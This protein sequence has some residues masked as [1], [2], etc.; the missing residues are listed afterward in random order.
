M[1]DSWYFLERR[2]YW[3]LL[4][5]AGDCWWRRVAAGL[6]L[7]LAGTGPGAPGPKNQTASRSGGLDARGRWARAST[8]EWLRDGSGR[9]GR[10]R[11]S[12]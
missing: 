11:E 6:L 2:F 1:G 12:V 7:E 8:R 10:A 3:W 9:S 5:T 4:V